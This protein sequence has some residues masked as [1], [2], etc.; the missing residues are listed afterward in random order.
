MRSAPWIFFGLLALS[1]VLM[2]FVPFGREVLYP[3]TLLGTWVHEMG[4][5]LTS[6]LLGGSFGKLVIFPDG[7]GAASVTDFGGIKSALTA[8]GGM[9]APSVYGFIALV[10]LRSEAGIHLFWW[11]TGLLLAFS[12]FV[13]V[14]EF[15]DF[16]WWFALG[17][18]VLFILVAVL[19]GLKFKLI[20]GQFVA[21]QMALSLFHTISY[22]FSEG[23]TV[24]G[25]TGGHSDV[26][27]IADALF[28]PYW[29]WGILVSIVTI[30]FTVGGLIIS[31]KGNRKRLQK[32]PA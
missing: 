22:A 7:S 4:H 21:A 24:G 29:L 26:S 3:F 28:G 31:F 30:G 12:T 27:A 25:E 11:V 2:M 14:R 18:S 6:L 19:G 10:V 1:L 15:F 9:I 32:A 13:W 8:F 23:A 16:G 5:G 17:M 20:L